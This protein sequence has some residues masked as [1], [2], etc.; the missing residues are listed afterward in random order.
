M[1]AV[2]MKFLTRVR[3]RGILPLGLLFLFL[4][5]APAFAAVDLR[6][7]DFTRLHPRVRI[8][9]I[10]DVEGARGNQLTGVGLVTGLPG[11]GDKSA[12]ATQMMRNMM[13]NFGVT[14]D[15]RSARSKNV[16][17]VSLTA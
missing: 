1:G 7:M 3:P 2:K 16:A 14:L 10:V 11:T 13:R 4:A 9:D 6:D 12:M 15:A 8:K 5:S 17:V